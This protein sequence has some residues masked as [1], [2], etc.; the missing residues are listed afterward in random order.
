MPRK[1]PM[2]RCVAT[3]EQLPKKELLRIVRTPE[4][5]PAVDLTGKANGRGAYLKKDPD[6]VQKARKTGILARA[7]EIQIPD[8]FWDEIMKA[9]K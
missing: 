7:L 8:S 9:V 3:G 2:R 4:G 1:I 5:I 6:A